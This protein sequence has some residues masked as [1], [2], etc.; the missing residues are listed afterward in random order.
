MGH[1]NVVKDM[2][3]LEER[4]GCKGAWPTRAPEEGHDTYTSGCVDCFVVNGG[5]MD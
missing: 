1:M 4:R 5:K 3:P 2:P